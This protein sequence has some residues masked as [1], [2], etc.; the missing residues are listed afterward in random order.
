MVI[1]LDEPAGQPTLVRANATSIDGTV[2]GQLLPYSYQTRIERRG[3]PVCSGYRSAWRMAEAQQIFNWLET[4]RKYIRLCKRQHCSLA[5]R[6][7]W[8]GRDAGSSAGHWVRDN[9]V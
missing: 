3:Q 4:F 2:S 8:R 9:G 7:L 1:Q 6:V 5:L